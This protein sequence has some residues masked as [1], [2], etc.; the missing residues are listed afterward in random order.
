MDLS[1]VVAQQQQTATQQSILDSEL[2]GNDLLQQIKEL[3]LGNN[4]I[5]VESAA[6]ADESSKD[7]SALLDAAKTMVV[8]NES[9]AEEMQAS[10]INLTDASKSMAAQKE[11][12]GLI[13]HLKS[14][15]GLLKTMAKIA[16]K[17]YIQSTKAGKMWTDISKEMKKQGAAKTKVIEGKKADNANPVGGGGG[18][19]F[20]DNKMLAASMAMAVFKA[21]N[22][23]TLVMTFLTKVLPLLIVFGLLLYGFIKGYFNTSVETAIAGVVAFIIAAAGAYFAWKIAKEAI[24]LAFKFAMMIVQTVASIAADWAEFALVAG[25]VV[26]VAAAFILVSVV[27]I[28]AVALIGVMIAVALAAIVVA[29]AKALLEVVKVIIDGIVYAVKAFAEIAPFLGKIITDLMQTTLTVLTEAILFIPKAILQ[30][31]VGGIDAVMSAISSIVDSIGNVVKTVLKAIGSAAGGFIKSLF[32]GNK[33]EKKKENVS[34]QDLKE[35]SIK[36]LS[37]NFEVGGTFAT[38]VANGFV[39]SFASIIEPVKTAM[40]NVANNF[41]EAY[42]A[43]MDKIN[44]LFTAVSKTV[45]NETSKLVAAMVAD[46]TALTTAFLGLILG[47]PIVGWLMGIVG[48]N[49]FTKALEPLVANTAQISALVASVLKAVQAKKEGYAKSVAVTNTVTNSETSVIDSGINTIAPTDTEGV[50]EETTTLRGVPS[51]FVTAQAFNAQMAAVRNSMKDVV[52]AIY[53]T[54][55]KDDKSGGLFSWW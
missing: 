6:S 50:N 43:T 37:A 13:A 51:N 9:N 14:A 45:Q 48:A 44:S 34:D 40:E 2:V 20:L 4:Q 28:A 41:N 18:V 54:A 53:A 12:S 16:A 38:L 31:V 35:L 36:A 15:G 52:D 49:S 22:P 39:D 27:L 29:L 26:V 55:P 21:L 33:E 19:P 32:G 47:L 8:D 30:L 24:F 25:V 1:A 5:Q 11:N 46:L 10:L 17:E 42:V 23:V 7:M 3:L